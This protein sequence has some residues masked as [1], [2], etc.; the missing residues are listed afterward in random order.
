VGLAELIDSTS[1]R[2]NWCT[3]I[4]S[5]ELKSFISFILPYVFYSL[6]SSLGEIRY[7]FSHKV[8]YVIFYCGKHGMEVDLIPS[9]ETNLVKV[10]RHPPTYNRRWILCCQKTNFHRV[11][12]FQS[13]MVVRPN[14]YEL[15]ICKWRWA[16]TLHPHATNEVFA[17]NLSNQIP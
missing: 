11:P 12:V 17:H 6:Q 13:T 4:I 1:L 16:W 14:F 9:F 7:H 15:P 5:Q 8:P 2:S 3:F 10:N